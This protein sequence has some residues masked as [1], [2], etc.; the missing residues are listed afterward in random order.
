M[1]RVSYVEP[2]QATGEVQQVYQEKLKGKPGN[3]Q[4][5]LAHQPGILKSFL[6]FY[7]SIG[8]SLEPRLY[9]MVY[10][11]VSMINGCQY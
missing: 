3:I 9:E 6:S 10:I 8:R 2:E 7:A 1:A 11:R 4:K 5:A